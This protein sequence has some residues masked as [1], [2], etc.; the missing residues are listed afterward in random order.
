MGAGED[1]PPRQRPGGGD[2]DRLGAGP[3]LGSA[4]AGAGASPAIR[5][6]RT[7]RVEARHSREGAAAGPQLEQRAIA[8]DCHAAAEAGGIGARAEQQGGQRAVACEVM[9]DELGERPAAEAVAV[10]DQ[11]EIGAGE[12]AAQRRERAEG[13]E[14]QRLLRVGEGQ[15]V[16]RRAEAAPDLLGAMMEVDRRGLAAGRRQ[17]PQRAGE[18]G[19]A[20]DRQ[21]RLRRHR[22]ERP[23]PR[24]EPGGEDQRPQAHG[25]SRLTGGRSSPAGRPDAL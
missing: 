16:E 19:L 8:A 15:A 23:Q 1:Q 22:G 10:D 11:P 2:P 20:G 3:A 12:E 7:C 14:Q 6:C 4:A 21:Q 17:A 25:Q 24:A 18:D 13:A 5:G 9:A